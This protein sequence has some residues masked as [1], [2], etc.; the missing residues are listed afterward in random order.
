MKVEIIVERIYEK[1]TN[2]GFNNKPNT[3]NQMCGP[4]LRLHTNWSSNL[5][6]KNFV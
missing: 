5:A 1:L 6:N 2:G 4:T 3:K